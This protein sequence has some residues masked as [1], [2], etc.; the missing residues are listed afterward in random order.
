MI[1]V[2]PEPSSVRP[3]DAPEQG[4]GISG[5]LAWIEAAPANLESARSLCPFL[6]EESPIY[7]GMSATDATWLR[8]HIIG[9]FA[10]FGLPE[11]GLP[12]VMEDL[13]TGHHT[14]LVAAACRAARTLDNP[15]ITLGSCLVRAL[16]NIRSR[17]EWVSFA[18]Y[19]ADAASEPRTTAIQEILK[20]VAWLG[21]RTGS[22][23]N[24]LRKI[25]SDESYGVPVWARKEAQ[26]LFDSLDQSQFEPPDCCNI[27]PVAHF[28]RFFRAKRCGPRN[29]AGL[30]LEDQDGVTTTFAEFL[31]GRPATIAFF[32][33]RCDNPNKCSFTV[34]N[35]AG[36]QEELR[37]RG[38]A[39]KV[40]LAAF[41]YDPL[42]DRPD[43]LKKFGLNRG[44]KFDRR[45]RFFRTPEHFTLLKDEFGLGVNF[46]EG[47][48][49]R[50]KIEL[51]LLNQ[52]GDISG[53]FQR[54][55]WHAKDVADELQRLS[56]V[57]DP[58]PPSFAHSERGKEI[59]KRS[60][61]SS[62][63]AGIAASLALVL[64]PKCPVCAAAY[65]SVIGLG[66]AVSYGAV[67]GLKVMFIG[68][69]IL[70]AAWMLRRTFVLQRVR[71]FLVY[72]LGL[73]LILFAYFNVV[74]PAISM[75]GVALIAL[76]T[77]LGT[78]G[79]PCSRIVTLRAEGSESWGRVPMT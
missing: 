1:A 13:Q 72:S 57:S 47:L 52:N 14:Y 62:R 34:S 77:V 71:P 33:T 2:E 67:R 23:L 7:A 10:R 54:L 69:M 40:V 3:G 61:V 58:P 26:A 20:T 16:L 60:A 11:E 74:T 45:N 42:F 49:N 79:R 32:Y 41:T 78:I 12:Y 48:V 31:N 43:R 76:G 9:T 17:D 65:L 35:L 39:D 68:V 25:I 29:L 18:G 73:G 37:K 70:H 64:F 66:G 50:H 38:L 75:C 28:A 27:G 21:P 44:F 59:E 5:L 22:A 56:T 63:L 4:P 55:Q 51:F 36:V 6:Q 30:E 15:P 53:S 46:V 19:K 24:Q 8:G